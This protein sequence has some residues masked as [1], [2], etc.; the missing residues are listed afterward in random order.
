MSLVI[1]LQPPPDGRLLVVLALDQDTATLI[2]DPLFPGALRD[3]MIRCLALRTGPAVSN[4][5]DDF[6]VVHFKQNGNVESE[7]LLAQ[8]LIQGGGLRDGARIAVEDK[9]VGAR[10]AVEA[11]LDQFV[12]EVIG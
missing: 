4:A 3:G 12:D 11:F 10:A 9:L 8:E 7:E 1:D 5:V 6:L 2:T